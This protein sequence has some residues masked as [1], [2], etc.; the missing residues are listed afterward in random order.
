MR[1]V[2]FAHKFPRASLA[3]KVHGAEGAEERFSSCH[4]GVVV[5]RSELGPCASRGSG[6][7]VTRSGGLS[8]GAR[9]KSL[10]FSRSQSPVAWTRHCARGS[11]NMT[12]HAAMCSVPTI[13]SGVPAAVCACVSVGVAAIPDVRR[14][15][16]LPVLHEG[17]L[18]A[19]TLPAL[20]VDAVALCA[21]TLHGVRRSALYPARF[22]RVHMGLPNVRVPQPSPGLRI[23]RIRYHG[24]L[25]MWLAHRLLRA[26]SLSSCE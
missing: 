14:E 3:P 9:G 11:S 18:A 7:T 10:C 16:H 8:M 12:V 20:L 13:R 15:G 17:S 6:G 19:C 26:W 25:R 22:V 24:P 21:V 23:R 2:I 5:E 1:G 4:S